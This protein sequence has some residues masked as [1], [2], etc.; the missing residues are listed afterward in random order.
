VT[1]VHHGGVQRSLFVALLMLTAACRTIAPKRGG[2]CDHAARDFYDESAFVMT[3]RVLSTDDKDATNGTPPS[4]VIDVERVLTGPVEKGELHVRWVPEYKFFFC[5]NDTATAWDAQPV[6]GPVPG[7]MLV[8]TGTFVQDRAVIDGW[9]ARPATWFNVRQAMR[10]IE[11]R[12]RQLKKE[13]RDRDVLLAST[14]RAQA[15][16]DLETLYAAAN[17]VLLTKPAPQAGS[18]D[19]DTTTVQIDRKVKDDGVQGQT[20]MP[21]AC[22]RMSAAARR[23][24][25]HRFDRGQPM[26]LF[27]RAL[28]R[29]DEEAKR[30]GIDRRLYSNIDFRRFVPVDDAYGALIETPELDAF[31]A[32]HSK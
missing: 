10:A 31:L 11:D 9:C 15:K 12:N 17:V 29:D 18:R 30:W 16:A 24:M 20:N 22:F 7:G 27:L 2:P 19:D 14:I 3:G 5:G 25:G 28:P 4:V 13:V 32:K 1:R 6:R 8:L 23:Q 26:V 21:F